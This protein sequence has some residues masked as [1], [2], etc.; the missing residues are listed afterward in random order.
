MAKGG[1]DEFECVAAGSGGYRYGRVDST[2]RL[3][4]AE[5]EDRRGVAKAAERGDKRGVVEVVGGIARSWT[6]EKGFVAE[7]WLLGMGM[8][9]VNKT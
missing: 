4:A 6:V 7:W 5:K 9:W 3:K 8:E 2:R 1:E